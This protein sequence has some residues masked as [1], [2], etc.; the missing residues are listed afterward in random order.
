MFCFPQIATALAK[1]ITPSFTTVKTELTYEQYCRTR[2]WHWG[3]GLSGEMSG[4][5]LEVE[6]MQEEWLQVGLWGKFS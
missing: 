6:N 4:G 5:F 3:G 2:S 1:K